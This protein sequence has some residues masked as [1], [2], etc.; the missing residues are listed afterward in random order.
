M[1]MYR[2]W[3]GEAKPYTQPTIPS[4]PIKSESKVYFKCKD[5]FPHLRSFSRQRSLRLHCEEHEKFTIGW[6]DCLMYNVSDSSSFIFVRRTCSQWI[7]YPKHKPQKKASLIYVRP[8]SLHYL[9]QWG[10]WR[11]QN[12]IRVVLSADLK[13]TSRTGGKLENG[14]EIIK[15][16]KHRALRVHEEW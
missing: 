2:A 3:V 13:Y 6:E 5:E 1:R 9:D 15:L 8:I 4:I 16:D 14:K 11:G 7:H 10:W 12:K